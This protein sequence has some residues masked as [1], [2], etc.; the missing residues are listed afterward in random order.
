MSY[1]LICDPYAVSWALALVMLVAAMV[2]AVWA[3]GLH[4]I[5]LSK[6]ERREKSHGNGGE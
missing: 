3:G 6:K 4:G 2:F 5:H 1:L